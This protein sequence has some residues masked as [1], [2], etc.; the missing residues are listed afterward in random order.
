MCDSLGLN[1]ATTFGEFWNSPYYALLRKWPDNRMKLVGGA[2][3]T[4]YGKATDYLSWSG[5]AV[6]RFRMTW[7]GTTM[8]MYRGS[9]G[10][11]L[12]LL[13]PPTPYSFGVSWS[14]Q[15]L[16]IQLGATFMAG[17]R[18]VRECGGAP[19]TVYSLLR[20][21][22]QDLADAA[23]P[24]RIVPTEV[25]IDLGTTDVES[26]LRR[27]V[28]ADGDTVA[29]AVGGRD[30]R[31]TVDPAT[32]F[33]IY[34]DAD[35]AFA[36]QGSKP[37]LYFR[38]DYYDSG[39]GGLA[40][41]YDSSD[42]AGQPHPYYK[43]ITGPALTGSNT[44]K[45]HM[46][47][48][49]DAYMGNRENNGADFRIGK[50]GGGYLFLDKV[51]VSDSSFLPAA[52]SGPNPADQAADVG[53][54]TSLSW[55][56]AEHADSYDVYFGSGNP[57]AFRGNQAGTTY[58]PGTLDRLTT[59]FWR[60]D[61]VNS[62]GTS[63]GPVWSFVTQTYP[64]DFDKDLDVDQEDFGLFQVCTSGYA[65]HYEPGCEHTDLDSD[66]DVDTGDFT[67][68]QTYLSGANTRPGS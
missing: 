41:Q 55:A 47:H 44:W 2:G 26:W 42:P 46:F 54:T 43:R 23:T 67:I 36:Y 18:G 45:Q 35:S 15:I 33:Y 52:T 3:G 6:Y 7:S 5:S 25:S 27:V 30:A 40:L 28:V 37:G 29:A 8:R 34:F 19:G 17:P 16:H 11:T 24:P 65:I 60:I 14:P 38:I 21:Y 62:L 61:S 68:F 13:D 48:V 4:D 32:D 10:Q 31:R 39:S 9:P 1:P 51:A 12:A 59:Y 66:G 64:G 63:T 56:A 58:D 57:P 49:T 53:I 22:E 50:D 20:I